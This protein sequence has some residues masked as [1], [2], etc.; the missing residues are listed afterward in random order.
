MEMALIYRTGSIADK[1]QLQRLVLAAYGKYAEVLGKEHWEKMKSGMENDATLL[2]LLAK[3]TVFVCE[4]EDAI[5]GMAFLIPSGNPTEHFDTT[6]SYIRWVGVDPRY[7]GRGIGKAL[8]R[9]CVEQAMATN[10]QTIALHTSE[11]QN[12][13]RHIYEGMGFNVKKEIGPILGKRY[14]VYTME[15]GV[16]KKQ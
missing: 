2:E 13:A 10:E 3:S 7:E 5:I 16:N 4:A 1:E 8:T 15:L 11:F 6:W 14:W 9:M 12:A